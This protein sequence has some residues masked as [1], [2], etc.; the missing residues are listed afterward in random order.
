MAHAKPFKIGIVGGGAGG[1]IAA[2]AAHERAHE[3]ET[4]VEI[5]LFE[6]NPRPG[7]KILI[8]GGGR[9]NITHEGPVEAVLREGFPRQAEHR[10]LK[11]ALYAYTNEDILHLIEHHGLAWHAR[12]NG[13]IFPDSGRAEDVLAALEA[14]LRARRITVRTRTRVT[15]V[16]PRAQGFELSLEGSSET[17]DALIL[18]TGGMSYAKTGTTGD[19]I[20]YAEMLGHRIV[21][22]TAA[23]APIYLRQP[24]VQELVGISLREV[25]LVAMVGRRVR[26]R[27]SGDV[28]LTHKGIS[29][30]ATLGISH[31]VAELMREEGAEVQ[32][33]VRLS[34]A[35]ADDL[36][37][38]Q[39]ERI[40]QQVATWISEWLPNR[41]APF[42]LEQAQV[43]AD[44]RWSA[45]TRDERKQLLA[46]LNAYALGVV[47]EV[48]LDRGEVTAGG[49]DL[50]EVDPR[51]L[52]SR[53]VPR[54]FFAGELLDVAGEI[55][56]YNL[57]AAYSTGHVAGRAAV[58]LAL[59]ERGEQQ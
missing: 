30:P 5:L 21:P 29:G 40:A 14:E 33:A 12:E 1:I 2:I 42:V 58:D 53:V 46:T 56:G 59:A 3:T 57:Q 55:G 24:P 18:A 10:F 19:G 17:V 11:S 45:L 34:Q 48:P 47:S 23:L 52:M 9:C 28:L 39:R 13:R 44:R 50:K 43:P 31:E 36:L 41:L 8:S 51:T 20:A 38:L 7:I 22:V 6:R 37:A 27:R 25:E 15:A 4:P 54:L 49:V 32:M 26:A 16:T 35:T